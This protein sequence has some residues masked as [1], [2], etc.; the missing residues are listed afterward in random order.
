MENEFNIEDESFKEFIRKLN[1]EPTDQSKSIQEQF[2]TSSNITVLLQEILN[3]L[4]SLNKR[5][6]NDSPTVH[7]RENTPL[8]KPVMPSVP[9]PEL[10]ICDTCNLKLENAM[11]YVCNNPNCT[12]GLN[13]A[14]NS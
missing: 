5:L 10:V 14:N 1:S 8:S 11:G 7:T 4:R 3:E 6:S 12:S 9:L 13:F 2:N